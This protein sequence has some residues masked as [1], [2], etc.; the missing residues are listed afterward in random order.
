MK[1]FRSKDFIC[2]KKRGVGFNELCQ[3]YSMTEAQM[4]FAIKNVFT[5]NSSTEFI[6]ALKEN[7][8]KVEKQLSRKNKL[9]TEVNTMS[10]N[11]NTNN[12]PQPIRH[13]CSDTS[14]EFVPEVSALSDLELL[15]K[16]ESALIELLSHSEEELDKMYR[17]REEVEQKVANFVAKNQK[18]QSQIDS[19]K[20]EINKLRYYSG[21]LEQQI[22][23]QTERS[24]HIKADLDS[25]RKDINK[26]QKVVITVMLNEIIKIDGMEAFNPSIEANEMLTIVADPIL[27]K[28][29]V[30]Q[31]VQLLKLKQIV[32]NISE[33]HDNIEIKF[34]DKSLSDAWEEWK[35]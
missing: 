23:K 2:A 11:D 5:G 15:Q 29:V 24:E 30:T 32:D 14:T 20:S 21:D 10:M 28:L 16:K 17:I 13:N 12:L 33:E 6:S 18:L 25:V 22:S 27:R 8:R 4:E 26:A 19:N 1:R 34:E 35:K 9:K 31:S 7:D 3:K